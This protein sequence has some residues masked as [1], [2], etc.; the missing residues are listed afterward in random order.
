MIFSS[1]VFLSKFLP[2]VLL[3]SF[4]LRKKIKWQNLFLL[5]MSLMFYAWGE[6]KYVLL[7][8]LSIVGNYALAI[9]IERTAHRRLWL[10]TAVFL[11]IGMLFVCKYLNW[12]IGI[13]NRIFDTSWQG[14]KMTLPIGISFYTFQALSY[15]IDVYRNTVPVQRNLIN[16]GLYVSLF[17]QLVAGPIVRYVDIEKQI[18]HRTMTVETFAM[19]IERFMIGFSKKIL[20]AD[21]FSVIADRAFA[22]NLES[23]LGIAMAWLGAIAYTLQIYYDFGGYSDMAI[24]LGKM[25]GFS[26]AENFNHP[27][28]ALS[29]TDFWRRWHISLSRWFRDYVYIPLGGNQQGKKKMILALAMTW[30]ATGIWHGANRTFVL[31]GGY[32]ESS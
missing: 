25:L 27:Y 20:L 29:V 30:I 18:M 1:T 3:G 12:G 15:V 19:G 11:N 8:L 16:V 26:F 5:L 24:G 9:L 21:S 6:P 14:I 22:M 7:M 32:T 10:F 28:M 4:I 31:W 17:P 23:T 13:L 2:I